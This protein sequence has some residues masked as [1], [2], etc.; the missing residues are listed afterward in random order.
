MKRL[1]A[2]L[3]ALSML[4]ITIAVAE[5]GDG[6]ENVSGAPETVNEQEE[7]TMANDT[8]VFQIYDEIEMR[9]VTFGNRYGFTLAGHLY[10]PENMTDEK[11]PAI[12]VAGPFGGVKEMASGLYAQEFAKMGFVA[13]AFDQSFTGESSGTP[14]NAASTDINTE[15]YLAAVDYLGSLSCVDRERIGLMGICGLA[16]MAISAAAVDTRIK[17]VA[18]ASMYDLS[19]SIGKGMMDSYTQEQQ[20]AVR[21][22]VSQNRWKDVDAGEYSY[23]P[24][25]MTVNED[26]QVVLDQ[27]DMSQLPPFVQR[28]VEY[29]FGMARHERAIGAW[30]QSTVQSFI[31]FPLMQFVDRVSPRPI[32]MIAGENAHSRYFSEDVY[33]QAGEPKELLIVPDADHV[34][35]YYNMDKIPF[36]KLKAFFEENLK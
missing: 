19:R 2:I 5:S 18:T 32:L 13:L 16:G 6:S 33:A 11:Y 17:A 1:L 15:D 4:A 8:R 12:A 22:Y 35:M 27:P 21:D 7:D 28:F 31:N 30:T 25:E 23:G 36:E 26:N 24:H 34:D 14:R 29:Y 3:I 20:D 10:L 9:P